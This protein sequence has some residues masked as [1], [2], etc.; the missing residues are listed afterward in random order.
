MGYSASAYLVYGFKCS[1][2][3]LQTTVQ[4]R[5]CKHPQT[6]GKFCPEC[7]KPMFVEK[8]HTIDLDEGYKNEKN[9]AMYSS[10]YESHERVI[11]FVLGY[12]DS[13]SEVSIPTPDMKKALLD[14]IQEHELDYSEMHLAVK[15]I[16]HHSY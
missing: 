15:L 9:L 8:T 3:D 1:K 2:Q 13:I 4:V 7:G 12:T 6:S 5:G 16:L 10:D 11:G 14:F